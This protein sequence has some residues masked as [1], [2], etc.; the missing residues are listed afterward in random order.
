[1][2]QSTAPAVDWQESTSARITPEDVERARSLI[3]YEEAKSER[4]WV[5]VANEDAIRAFAMSYGCDNPLFCDPDYARNTRWGSVVGAGPM[6]SNIGAPLKGDPKP[7]W[8]TRARKGLLRNVHWIHAATEWDWY[9]QILPGD[10]IY[11]FTGDDSVEEKKSEFSGTSLL[12]KHRTIN[13]NQRGEVVC[14]MRQSML[15]TERGTATKRGKYM[16]IEPAT[17]TDE[18]LAR[19][20][21]IYAAE[22]VRG[23]ETRYWE[24][25]DAGESLGAM[26]KGPLTV[27]DI[28][29]FHTTGFAQLPFGPAPGRLGYKRRMRMPNAYVKNSKGI[30]DLVMRI[31]WEDEWAQKMGSPMAYDYGFQ[32]ECWLYHYVSDWCGDDGIVLHMKNE[33]RK[34]NYIG[35]TQTITGEVVNKRSVDGQSLVDVAVRFTSQRGEV[36]A[37]SEATIALPSRNGSPA[38]FPAVPADVAERASAFMARHRELGGT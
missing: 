5:T 15:H 16:H 22:Q 33:M 3:G 4:M 8:V 34:F 21:A 9:R 26:A 32:R 28:L 18:D 11:K 10:R 29:A 25:T 20:D 31:H 35:D 7:E 17:Y 30:P 2:T 1:M 38:D 23:A 36:T 19:I 6:I 14:V 27:S 24:D 13:M 12:R 37:T